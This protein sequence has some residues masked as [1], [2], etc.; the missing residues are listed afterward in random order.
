[1]GSVSYSYQGVAIHKYVCLIFAISWLTEYLRLPPGDIGTESVD[2]R[3]DAGK[4]SSSKTSVS[5]AFKKFNMSSCFCFSSA[6]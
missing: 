2:C 6:C 1:M 4:N 3:H 5:F